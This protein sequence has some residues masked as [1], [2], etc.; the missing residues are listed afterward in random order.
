MRGS[1]HGCAR[2]SPGRN[3]RHA[4]RRPPRL[5]ASAGVADKLAVPRA[6]PASRLREPRAMRTAAGPLRVLFLERLKAGPA[7]IKG[8][9]RIAREHHVPGPSK[10]MRKV[11]MLTSVALRQQVLDNVRA[12][13][14][15]EAGDDWRAAQRESPWKFRVR[16]VVTLDRLRRRR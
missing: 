15:A 12:R 8:P 16:P 1:E 2:F 9:A 6:R 4:G 7:R 11:R 10:K 14:D 3:D 13:K 5:V